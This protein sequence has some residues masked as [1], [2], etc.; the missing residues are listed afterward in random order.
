[1]ASTAAAGGAQGAPPRAP[2]TFTASRL[3]SRLA[4][5]P[6]FKALDSARKLHGQ[7]V[8]QLGELVQH[9]HDQAVQM[10]LDDVDTLA[11]LVDSLFRA[12]LGGQE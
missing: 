6:A 4:S 10:A 2:P 1:M 5:K 9:T 3:A 11:G 12:D 7:R 8:K